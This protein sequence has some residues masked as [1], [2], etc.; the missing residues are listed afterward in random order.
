MRISQ[1]VTKKQNDLQEMHSEKNLVFMF[2]RLFRIRC[3][4]EI[5][6]FETEDAGDG[7]SGNA[8]M[9]TMPSVY[10]M[11]TFRRLCACTKINK[12]EI[13][14]ARP[15]AKPNATQ[16]YCEGAECV[17]SFNFAM[18]VQWCAEPFLWPIISKNK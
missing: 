16:C 6:K 7:A 4:L 3:I 8:R 17:R 9:C 10:L 18:C 11:K 13:N 2:A 14:R 5:H 15:T 1:T 12:T